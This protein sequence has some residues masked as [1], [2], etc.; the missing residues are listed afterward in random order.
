M[1]VCTYVCMHAQPKI[2]DF[3]MSIPMLMLTFMGCVS[4]ALSGSSW[5]T[6]RVAIFLAPSTP[7]AN[8]PKRKDK[9]TLLV[10]TKREVEK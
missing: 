4:A 3:G 7:N 6:L 5:Y 9:T 10:E 8:I 2:T 1:I